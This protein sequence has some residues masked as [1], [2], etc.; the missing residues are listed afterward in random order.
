MDIRVALVVKRSSPTSGLGRNRRF[1]T[2]LCHDHDDANR[3][4]TVSSTSGAL[5]LSTDWNAVQPPSDAARSSLDLPATDVLAGSTGK[6]VKGAEVQITDANGFAFSLRANLAGNFYSKETVTPPLR[7][8]CIA[9]GGQ[10][11]CQ[12]AVG[13]RGELFG[14]P[15]TRGMDGGSVESQ[16]LSNSRGERR[17][18]AR[19]RKPPSYWTCTTGG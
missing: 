2:L 13:L 11:V 1:Q 4:Q 19:H 9:F 6:A 12:D 18:R 5:I 10:T 14:N 16:Q 17:A 8:A 7:S 15:S 3:P